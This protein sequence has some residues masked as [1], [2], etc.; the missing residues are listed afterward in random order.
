MIRY[1]PTGNKDLDRALTNM[2]SQ[3]DSIKKELNNDSKSD[4][5]TTIFSSAQLSNV[6]IGS[7][8]LNSM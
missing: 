5:K 4:D 8:R 2:Q 1:K 3:L 6:S 7:L